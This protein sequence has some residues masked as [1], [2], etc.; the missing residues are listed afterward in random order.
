[1]LQ[2][3]TEFY[4]CRMYTIGAIVPAT[5]LFGG[6]RRF[7]ELGERFIQQGHRMVILSPEGEPPDWF[8]YNVEV[9][10]VANIGQYQFTALFAIQ[11]E[12]LQTLLEADAAIRVFYHVLISEEIKAIIKHPEIK[13]FA[14][15]TNILQHDKKKYGIDAF[16]LKGGVNLPATSKDVSKEEDVFTIMC[17]GRLGRMRKGTRFVVKAAERLYRQGYP[18]KLL[19]YDTPVDENSK[20]RI[21][22]FKADVPYEFVLNHPV[23]EN[24]SLFKRASVFVSAEKNAGWSNSSAEALSCG[25]PLIATMS[26]TRDFLIDGETGL[27]VWRN[28]FSISRAIK[29]LMDSKALQVKLSRNGRKKIEEFNW[30]K[31]A[32]DILAYI[33][34]LHR[35]EA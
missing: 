30:D 14:N 22:E 21:A 10:K 23:A 29:K 35:K 2:E 19:L 33:N 24:E 6:V 7:F 3:C 16:L 25:I 4:I 31:L 28:S 26:G 11:K 8:Q 1:M 32:D 15:S 9:D 17:F 5:K 12:M 18:V 34:N 27:V 20:Q 13:I